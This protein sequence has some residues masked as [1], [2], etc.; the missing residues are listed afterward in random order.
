M[1]A[2][3]AAPTPSPTPA[4]T[5][6]TDAPTEQPAQDT[7]TED[8]GFI[9]ICVNRKTLVRVNYRG[10]DDARPGRA[11]YFLPLRAKVP[12]TG[13]KAKKGSFRQ[14]SGETYRAPAKGGVGSDVMI[15][16]IDDRVQVCVRQ[17]TRIR[18][19]DIR[20]DDG[21]KGYAWYY[22]RMDGHVPRVGRQAEE[23]SFREPYSEAYRARRSGGDAAK[24]AIDYE[25][26]DAPEETE[27]TDE[28]HCTATIDGDCVDTDHCVETVDGVCTQ[29]DDES[30]GPVS[31]KCRNVFTGKRWTRRCRY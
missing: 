8:P 17:A 13:S 4:R 1:V 10:C 25:D 11:W 15:T 7:D 21:E 20:C 19:S 26:P 2:G 27:E 23:G 5:P 9:E 22:I 18:V 31:G 6:A 29:T 30:L 12:A 24:A 28:E 14:P 16:D 3:C